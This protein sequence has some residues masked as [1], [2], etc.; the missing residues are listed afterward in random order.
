MDQGKVLLTGATGFLGSAILIDI[1]KAGY[2]VNIAVRSEAKA[3]LIR[4]APAIASLGKD[5]AC[6]Y[7]IVPDL[8]AEGCLDEATAGTALVIHCAT[9]M[10]F[11]DGDMEQDVIIPAVKCTLRALESAQKAGTVK[12]V[13]VTSSLGA[14]AGPELVGGTYVPPEEIFLG[15]KPNDDFGPPFLNPLVGYCAAKTAALKRSLEWMDKAVA[16]GSINF[17]LINLAP[18]YIFGKVPLANSLKD[19]YATS[20][21]VLLPLITGAGRSPD[22]KPGPAT[23]CGGLTVDDFV[24]TVHR[25]LDLDGVKTPSS[26]PSR[27]VVTYAYSHKFEWNE[28]FPIIARKWPEEVKKGILAGEGDYPTKPNIN[29]A[30]EEFTKTYGGFK[31]QGVEGI[32]DALVP[33]YLELLE[34][35]KSASASA[36]ASA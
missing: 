6:K 17:D 36:S 12:R 34:K 24:E 13:V 5:S 19:L 32:L 1:L 26:G 9:P 33:Q 8:T 28:V 22:G 11:T 14:F 10:P 7:F 29:F 4:E 3:K 21:Q 31:L 35:E 15:E 25:S 27:H 30:M 20:N 18:C 23:L 2:T 16:E